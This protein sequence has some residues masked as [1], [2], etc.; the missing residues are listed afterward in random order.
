M[1]FLD[2]QTFYYSTYLQKF[3]QKIVNNV[4]IIAISL[5]ILSK[6]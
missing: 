5:S 4:L 1:D 3:S 6:D 2:K